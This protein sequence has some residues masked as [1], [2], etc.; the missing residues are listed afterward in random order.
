MATIPGTLSDQNLSTATQ[1]LIDQFVFL[2]GQVSESPVTGGVIISGQGGNQNG[3]GVNENQTLFINQGTDAPVTAE[4]I[5][6][7]LAITVILPP[8]VD[9]GVS[10][11]AAQVNADQMAAYVNDLIGKALDD[12]AADPY[13]AAYKAA[14][15]K[16]IATLQGQVDGQQVTIRVVSFGDASGSASS[17]VTTGTASTGNSV[18]FDAGTST[19][20]EVFALRLDQLSDDTIV[21]LK[22]VEN[23]MLIDSGSVIIDGS[24]AARVVGDIT[25]QK[26][27]G[28]AGN[29]TLVGGG[30]NDTL[31]G[32]AGDDVIGFSAI[33]HYTI[34]GFGNG[35]DKLAFDIGTITN[36]AQ[37]ESLITGVNEADGNVT[38]VFNSGEASITLIGV[39]ADQISADLV[40]FTL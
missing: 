19:S 3:T 6:G 5:D 18:V 23:V 31:V 34:E 7:A 25:D 29:D 37:L 15:E 30:G 9:L 26:I 32:G 10:G 11:P 27:T 24:T 28:G 20:N 36:V 17:S 22:N 35:N 39:S 33:G 40:Q 38:Y 8:G 16:A 12:T 2:G 1:T 21:T 4:I 13:I 14:L